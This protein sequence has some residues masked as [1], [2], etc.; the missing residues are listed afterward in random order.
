MR[1]N[2][3]E[4]ITGLT[5][6]AIRLYESKGLLR[7][8]REENGYRN[9]TEEDV[10]VLKKIKLLRSVGV[11]IA[12]I[13]LYLFG[14]V[15]IEELMDQRKTEIMKE[16]GIHSEM[17]RI[18]ENIAQNDHY[19]END[20]NDVFNEN[21]EIVTEDSGEV[22][23]GI[24]LGTTT[25]SA[26]V[27]D[28]RRKVQLESYTLAHNSY[29]VSNVFSEQ[30]T[31]VIIEK[32]EKLLY[33]IIKCYSNV[34]SI[35]VT[36]QMHG[37]VYIDEDGK[38]VSNLI[39]WQDKR[40]DLVLESGK[41]TVELIAQ[42]TDE[43]VATG[44]GI[45]THYYNRCKNL[46]PADAVGFCSIMDY[47]GMRLCGKKTAVMHA[48]VAA[49]LGLFDVQ[50]GCFMLEKL[51]HLGIDASFLPMVTRK[52]EMVGEC[53]G[54]PVSVA[55]GDNQASFLGS[56]DNNEDSVLVN[57]GTGSQISAVSE[58]CP[59]AAGIE[60]RPFLEGN[61]L[62]CGSSLC[63]GSAYETLERFFRSFAVSAGLQDVPQYKTLNA[64]AWEAY[65]NGERG[66]KID[67]SFC[68][69]RTEPSCR[70]FIEGISMQNFTPSALIIG[71]LNG[72]LEEL[73]QLYR[74]FPC[75]KN[76]V[77]ASG[78][79]IR[80]NKVLQK[81]L[82]EK[83]GMPVAINQVTEEAATGAALFSALAT[84]KIAYCNGF[85]EYINY[86]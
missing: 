14:V 40:A 23:V 79:G 48:S 17:Y 38:A 84:G 44:Y 21:E 72:I 78:G 51:A 20:S 28:L 41:T 22:V 57:I 52:N 60:I 58:Y 61:Y 73:Y 26:V 74:L 70:G 30:N 55:L 6:K 59:V 1:I 7:V 3:V 10:I 65:Q 56:V 9:Y 54:I 47:F 77:I 76:R 15:N 63:G 12:D 68:G 33:H 32:A 50:K 86:D 24:D 43:A 45:A 13:K 39:N 83:T 80:K 31:A 46:V 35:G 4:R 82:E 18:C 27:Y 42:L 19:Y 71:V 2:T 8:A 16:S 62:I 67:T 66:L 37:I 36:G 11:S 69:K 75:K 64:L 25:I 34:V 5:P 29:V 85:S 53:R 49:S 81:I